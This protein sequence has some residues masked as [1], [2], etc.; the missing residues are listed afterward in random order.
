M[1]GQVCLHYLSDFSKIAYV[2]WPLL[3]RSKIVFKI[4]YRLMQV[5]NITECSKGSIL[6][7]FWPYF[8]LPFVIRSLFCLF[9][10]GHFRQVLQT[11]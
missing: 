4:N 1:D 9:V 3:N 10:S 8:K 6:Q 11:L 7:Y 2:K 5:K